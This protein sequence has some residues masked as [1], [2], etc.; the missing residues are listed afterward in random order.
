[1]TKERKQHKDMAGEKLVCL[2]STP[3]SL[4]IDH[5]TAKY[6]LIL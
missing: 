2:A 3:P 4:Y 1:M 5:F 6:A